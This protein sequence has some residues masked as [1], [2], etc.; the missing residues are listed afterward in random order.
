VQ[1][2]SADD[3]FE[4]PAHTFVGHFIGSPG[5]NFLTAQWRDGALMVGQ[6]RMDDVPETLAAKLRDAGP[7]KLGVRPEYLRLAE[8]GAPGAVP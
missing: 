5:M 6:R 4:R 8:A 1:V 2:G 7:V 3:L